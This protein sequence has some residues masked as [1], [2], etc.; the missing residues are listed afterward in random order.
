[1]TKLVFTVD[2]D[3]D[4]AWPINGSHVGGSKHHFEPSFESSQKGFFAL[5]E[6]VNELSVP[7]TFFFE[8]ATAKRIGPVWL[9][10]EVACHG[11]DHEDFTGKKTGR[12][13]PAVKRRVILQKAKTELEELFES[14]VYGFRAPYL[15][16]DVALLEMLGQNG[17]AYDSSV[18]A[19]ELE[20]PPL[21]ELFLPSWRDQNA[22]ALSGYLWPLMEGKRA[23]EDYVLAVKQAVSQNEP[24]VVL[25]THSWHTH[26]S[27]EKGV[28]SEGQ[29]NRNVGRVR[30]LL[31]AFLGLDGL[32]FVLGKEA[33][34]AKL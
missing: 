31:D 8:A 9:G 28:L 27:V 10:H 16:W 23:V 29:A 4:V 6:L 34:Q 26:A 19:G 3:R 25:A 14:R 17:F 2:V 13:L 5:L 20:K 18:V 1:M 33:V 7:T 32:E 22:K 12:P 21:P 11:F 30:E 15:H 24:Y